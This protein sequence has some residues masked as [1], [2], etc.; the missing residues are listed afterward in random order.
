ML[1]IATCMSAA[2]NQHEEPA[3]LFSTHVSVML[4]SADSWP[5]ALDD[6]NARQDWHWQ[7]HYDLQQL[8]KVMLEKLAPKYKI[9]EKIVPDEPTVVATQRI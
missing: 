2:G 9:P 4:F 3:L 7:H 5:Q 1:R 8:V 6:S